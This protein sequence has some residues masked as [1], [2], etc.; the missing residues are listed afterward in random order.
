MRV[1]P[2][3]VLLAAV[4]AVSVGCA[5]S[6]APAE[7]PAAS[8]PAVTPSATARPGPTATPRPPLKL[9][10]QDLV[11]SVNGIGPYRIGARTD[12]LRAA[13]L[14][15][16]DPY[17]SGKKE[18]RLM[19]GDATGAY[20]GSIILDLRDDVLV[21]IS[22][23]GGLNIRTPEGASL[24]SGWKGL[25]RIYGK[26]IEVSPEGKGRYDVRVYT[27]RFGDRA[28]AFGGH[29]IRPGIGSITAGLADVVEK[30]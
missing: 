12:E 28:L 17:P 23:S 21:A 10:S 26:R 13:G 14:L 7:R 11:L 27:V 1:L 4:A 2:F 24:G 8:G 6:A 25:R 30:C 20:S 29:P 22:T 15:G 18:C 19:W 9:R 16:N 5:P 3:S